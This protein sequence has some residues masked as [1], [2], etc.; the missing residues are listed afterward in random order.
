MSLAELARKT[1]KDGTSGGRRFFGRRKSQ[2][3]YGPMAE[4]LDEMA[5]LGINPRI[6]L[7]KRY[8]VYKSDEFVKLTTKQISGVISDLKEVLTDYAT[9]DF[10][11][12]LAKNK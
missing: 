5:K 10:R 12:R 4:A 2:L 7:S 9:S 8:G 6:F 11:K 1:S 3:V